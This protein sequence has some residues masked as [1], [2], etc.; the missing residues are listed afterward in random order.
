[1][2]L[3]PEELPVFGYPFINYTPLSVQED[4]QIYASNF[5]KME[6]GRQRIQK[7]SRRAWKMWSKLTHE[8]VN[9]LH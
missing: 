8:I 7:S 6:V 1:M 4:C 9:K 5:D 3:S 2:N